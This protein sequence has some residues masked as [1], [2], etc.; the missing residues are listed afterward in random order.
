M[1]VFYS[2]YVLRHPK[3]GVFYVGLTKDVKTRSAAHKNKYG[4][5]IVLEVIDRCVYK[6]AHNRERYWIERYKKAGIPLKN[7]QHLAQITFPMKIYKRAHRAARIHAAMSGISI[8]DYISRLV[9]SDPKRK[10]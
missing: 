3:R 9:L 5:S 10:K 4:N 1:R 8:C 2:I 7:K 6:N